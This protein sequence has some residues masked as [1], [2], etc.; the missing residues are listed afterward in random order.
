MSKILINATNAEELRVAIIKNNT[1]EDLDIQRLDIEQKKSNIYK[2]KIT[3]LEPSLGAAFVDYGAE[4]HGFLPLKEI[5]KHYFNPAKDENSDEKQQTKPKITEL[6]NEGQELIIQV[7][8]EERGNKGAALT[9]FISLAGSYLVLMTNTSKTGGISRRIEGKEREELKAT[10]NKLKLPENNGLIIRTAGVGKS[11]EELQ[12][13][14][15]ALLNHA[16]A[17]KEAAQG[18]SAPFLI[19]RESDVVIRTLRDYIRQDV[20]EIIVDDEEIKT[21]IERYLTHY[22]PAFADKVVLHNDKIPLFS[23]FRIEKQIEIAFKREIRLPSGGSIVIDPTEAL[24]SIDVNSSRATT[25]KNIEETAL[26]TNLEAASEIARQLRLRDIGGLIVID[27]IDML[28]FSNQKEVANKLREELSFDRAR[29]RIGNITKFGLMEMSRQRLRP[30]LDT[31]I[32]VKCPRCEGQG[33]IRSIGSLTLSILR[34][35][36]EQASD[37]SIA[38]VQ[39]HL[40]IDL[41]TYILNEKRAVLNKIENDHNT[42]ILIIPN[43]FIKTPKY[44]IRSIRQKDM[45]RYNFTN[46]QSYKLVE[47]AKLVT[48]TFEATK[49]KKLQQEKAVL[50]ELHKTTANSANI[51]QQK[52]VNKKESYLKKIFSLV[53]NL[54]FRKNTKKKQTNARTNNRPYYKNSN[55]KKKNYYNNKKKY[56]NRRGSRGGK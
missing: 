56:Y 41:A 3:R 38:Q 22:R 47:P 10:L 49:K 40:P 12:W 29:V 44:K 1:L 52:I 33:S 27:F 46:T 5:S 45:A 36:E 42:Q 37:N 11:A 24:I 55:Y 21:K 26:N 17:I 14:L 43:Q 18:K 30:A 20:E 15:D 25:G 39:I 34:L 2:G 31:N 51:K 4:K 32:Q 53:L 7:A 13:D 23:K 35:A 8:K 19:M 6:L 50:E 54:V 16:N 48:P 28:N 9:T